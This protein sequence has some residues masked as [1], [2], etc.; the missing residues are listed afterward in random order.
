MIQLNPHYVLE[1]L[2]G[3]LR[4]Y[5]AFGMQLGGLFMLFKKPSR[6]IGKMARALEKFLL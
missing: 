1:Y 3:G 5:C 2:K 6:S 4:F